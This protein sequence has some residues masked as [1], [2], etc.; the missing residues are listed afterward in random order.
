[1]ARSGLRI[2]FISHDSG[3]TG[4]PIG[5]LA[6]MRWLRANTD[7]EIGTLLRSP[8]PLEPAFRELGPTT[9]LGASFLSRSRLRRRL[10]GFLPRSLQEETGKIRSLFAAGNYDLIYSNTMTNGAALEALASSGVPV[11]THVHEL[12]FWISRAGPENLRRTLARTTRY[13]AVSQAV[14]EYLVHQHR[15]PEE[16]I[17]VIYEHIRELPSVPSPA[18]KAAARKNLGIPAGAFV[19]GGCGAEHWRKGR[20]LIPQLLSALR[21]SRPQGEFHFVW[22]GRSGSAAEEYALQHDLRAAGVEGRFHSSGEVADPFQLYPAMDAFALLSREDPYPLACLE[23]AATEVPVVC[24]ADAGGMPE[25]ARDGCGLVSPYLDL[26]QMAR[27]L[28]RLADD[29]ELARDCGRRARAKVARENLLDTTAPQLKAV[30]DRC[31]GD[32]KGR[33]ATDAAGRPAVGKL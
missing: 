1:M 31:V 3:R 24:F 13:V 29:P 23:V 10:R 2:L 14:R 33:T 25:F 32:G 7:Y 11:L 9:T 8:G 17:A 15:I 27:D 16:K 19:V 22:V 12:G 21:R 28:I 18:E 30:I 26:E 20:D 4:A 6:F 5:L